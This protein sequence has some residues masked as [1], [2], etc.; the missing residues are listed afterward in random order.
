M[1]DARVVGA[2][3]VGRDVADR[4]RDEEVLRQTRQREG[5]L[6]DVTLAARER[7]HIL[8]NDLSVGVAALHMLQGRGRL[9]PGLD[10][11][12][13]AAADAL[14]HAGTLQRLARSETRD[15]PLGPVLDLE[16]SIDR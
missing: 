4:R 3:G 14:Q 9:A 5:R 2:V 1:R 11:L 10:D 15:T 8:N 12:V 6:E 7:A 13:R 16:R